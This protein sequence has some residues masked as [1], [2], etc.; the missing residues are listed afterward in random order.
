MAPRPRR[1]ARP[2]SSRSPLYR[3]VVPAALV[4]LGAVMLALLLLAGGVLLGVLS[5]PGR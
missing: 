2:A 1:V 5:Y 4:L 3:L